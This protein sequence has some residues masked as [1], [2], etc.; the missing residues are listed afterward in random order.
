M[1]KSMT[2]SGMTGEDVFKAFKSLP[3]AERDQVLSRIIENKRLRED[4]VDLAIV[5]E[6]KNEPKRPFRDFVNQ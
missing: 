1:V 5:E 3:K 2:M 4:L 6:R